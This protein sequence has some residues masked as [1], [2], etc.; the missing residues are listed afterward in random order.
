MRILVTG[1]SG[2]IGPYIL[3]EL[4]A[5][6]HD[7][8]CYSRTDPPPVAGAAFVAGDIMDL[9]RL[10]EASR[11]PTRSCTWPPFPGHAGRRPSG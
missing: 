10:A 7:V 3:R 11:A 1:G 6:G 9:E 2:T 8:T 5:G 4:L